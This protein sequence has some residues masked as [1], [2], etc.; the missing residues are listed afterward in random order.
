MWRN[1]SANCSV[2]VKPKESGNDLCLV[3]STFYLFTFTKKWRQKFSFYGAFLPPLFFVIAPR[4]IKIYFVIFSDVCPGLK[5]SLIILF[6][7][8]P[9]HTCALFRYFSGL[10]RGTNMKHIRIILF[11]ECVTILTNNCQAATIH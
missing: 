4:C 5:F 9:G 11:L 7:F 1:E 2:S 10:S 3:F 8:F 6:C